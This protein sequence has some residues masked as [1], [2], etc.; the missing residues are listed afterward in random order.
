MKIVIKPFTTP[1]GKYLYDRETNSIISINNDEYESF[2]RIYKNE[3]IQND[4][5]LIN[6]YQKMGICK[7][8]RLI[9]VEHPQNKTIDFLLKNKIEKIT[10]QVT[11]NCN[12]RCS[13]CAYSGNIYNQRSHSNKIMPY[14]VM[15]KSIDFIMEHSS[16]S[17][18]INIGFYG[19][20]PL[21]EIKNI[22]KLINEYILPKYSEKNILYSLTTNGT[23]FTDENIKFL[24]DN[25]FDVLISIDGPKE[26]HNKNRV[27]V[28]GEGSFDVM[29]ENLNYIKEKY[30]NFFNKISFNTV[31]AP[32]NDFKCVNDFFDA[33]MVIEDNML[34]SSTLSNLNNIEDITYNDLYFISNRINRT[35][36]LLSYLKYISK[37]KI[38]KLY[39]IEMSK[40]VRFYNDLN[41]INNLTIISHPGGPCIPGARRPLIDIDGNIYPCERVNEKSESMII[42]NIYSGFDMNKVK[43]ILNI[44]K[45]TEEQCI[46]C[47]NF[48]HCGMCAAS[49]VDDHEL[50]ANK[51]LANCNAHKNSTLANF[52]TICL[53][54]ENKFDFESVNNYV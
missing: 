12:L 7:E 29:M 20:E 4:Y 24:S 46:N 32:D 33:N 54:K 39:L 8:T 28:N 49:S 40:I 10:L 50:S 17:K 48:I 45:L 18:K 52:L 22:K 42:G 35:K 30:P 1:F 11:Q 9:K 53:L 31:I 51:R 43:N 3:M 36:L 2:E 25:N 21:L 16:N 6:K 27:F 5:E 44:G 41:Q 14:E 34:Y 47:W 38:S 15:T 26:I 37:E 19:G 13:Y 23:V